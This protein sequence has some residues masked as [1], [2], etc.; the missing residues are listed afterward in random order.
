ML[1]VFLVSTNVFVVRSISVSDTIIRNLIDPEDVQFTDNLWIHLGIVLADVGPVKHPEQYFVHRLE[2]VIKSALSF[3]GKRP[4]HL[5]YISDEDSLEVIANQTEKT[6]AKVLRERILLSS[7]AWKVP[8]HHIPTFR[9]EFVNIKSITE[10][11]RTQIDHMKTRFNVVNETYKIGIDGFENWGFDP[12]VKYR[13]DLFYVSPFYHLMFPFEKFVVVDADIEFKY[14]INKL[15]EEF[16]KFEPNQLYAFAKDMSPLYRTLLHS[17][18][19]ENPETKLGDPGNLQGINTGVVLL[20]LQKMR[21]DKTF[22]EYLNSE[23][24][25]KL[26]DK[27][28]FKGFI[29][30]QDWWN[31]VVWDNPQFV[32]F[33]DCGFNFQIKKEFNQHPFDQL[34]DIYHACDSTMMIKHG[35]NM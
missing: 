23:N 25:D 13:H 19:K 27:Y 6:L 9:V 12:V 22:Q 14:N 24:I 29:G 34:F 10:K 1:G 32:H 31:I 11:Y 17:Y 8:D 33:L 4:I 26:C 2:P 7:E 18:R 20:N 16:E 15:F 28:H 21:S 30:D 3:S 5:V 35:H